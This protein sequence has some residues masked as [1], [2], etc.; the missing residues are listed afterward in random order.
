[1]K[2]RRVRIT[3]KEATRLCRFWQRILRLQDWTLAVRVVRGNGLILPEN[4]QG[5]CLMTP[6][7][8]EALIQLLDPIDYAPDCMSHQDMEATLVH[9]ILHPHFVPFEA[10][11]ET[12]EETAQEQAIHV[13]SQGLVH[14]KR[15]G[16]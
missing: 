13:I 3:E 9:E 1:M 5:R 11:P 7:R 8:K 10:K 16:R 4:T 15:G 14:L 6:N 12:P 2:G